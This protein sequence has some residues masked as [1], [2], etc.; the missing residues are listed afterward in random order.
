VGRN[1]ATE[2]WWVHAVESGIVEVA[3]RA[4]KVF[5]FDP[6]LETDK[7][8]GLITG[9]VGPK[10]PDYTNWVDPPSEKDCSLTKREKMK[11]PKP[12][13]NTKERGNASTFLE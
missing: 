13:K 5:M 6:E 11:N 3:D 10:Y 12:N 4:T 1:K 2:E 7:I 9:D 8:E